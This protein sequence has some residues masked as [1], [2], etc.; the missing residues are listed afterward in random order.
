LQSALLTSADLLHKGDHENILRL[1]E[2]AYHSSLGMV[3]AGRGMD[4]FNVKEKMRRYNHQATVGK[5][6]PIGIRALDKACFGGLE[7]GMLGFFMAGTHV[8]KT[9]FMINS[10][11]S[12]L[13]KGLNVTHVTLEMSEEQIAARYDARILGVPI[14]DIRMNSSLYRK[15]MRQAAKD[16]TGRL[17]IVGWSSGECSIHDIR[18][19]LARR[20]KETGIV[21]DV[22]YVDYVDLMRSLRSYTDRR[23]ELASDTRTLRAL[24]QEKGVGIW[25]ATQIKKDDWGKESVDLSGAYESGEKMNVADFVLGLARAKATKNA[26]RVFNLKDRVA[27]KVGMTVDCVVRTDTCSVKSTQVSGA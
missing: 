11:V 17:D 22:V 10:G 1:V 14:N 3:D 13:L 15:E 7:P 24:A 18:A 27:G 20:E 23:H 26:V 5:R 19:Y 16:I 8:G 9:M 6:C 25:T 12:A 21:S 4:F 2:T